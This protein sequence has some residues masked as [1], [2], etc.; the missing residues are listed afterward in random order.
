MLWKGIP[1]GLVRMIALEWTH[2]V[3]AVR[4]GKKRENFGDLF[5]FNDITLGKFD[6]RAFLHPENKSD[7]M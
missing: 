6:L 1:V 7:G 2:Q 3:C 4:E 5:V